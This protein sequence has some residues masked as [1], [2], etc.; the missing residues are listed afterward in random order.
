V[1][2]H[3]KSRRAL[4]VNKVAELT[5]IGVVLRPVKKIELRTPPRDIGETHNESKDRDSERRNGRGRSDDKTSSDD[6]TPQRN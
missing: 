5:R 1:S 3:H 6:Q 2:S 4:A